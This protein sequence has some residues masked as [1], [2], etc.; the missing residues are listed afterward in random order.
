MAVP[1]RRKRRSSIPS[2]PSVEDY[3]KF[4][5]D[6]G[7]TLR[8]VI[9]T[10]THAD[11]ISGALLL[12]ERTDASYVM[13]KKAGSNHP[14]DRLTDGATLAVGALELEAI[15]TPGHTKDSVTLKLPG[16]V[17]TG[18]WLFIVGTQALPTLST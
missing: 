12:R 4:L 14:N 1:R 8:Y 13:H 18:D 6:N 5:D 16:A 9:D 15:A 2:S 3:L 11:H 7:W 17:L 10:H